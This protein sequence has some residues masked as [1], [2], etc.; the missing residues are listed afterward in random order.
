MLSGPCFIGTSSCVGASEAEA[1]TQKPALAVW[2]AP[3]GTILALVVVGMP[4]GTYT[5]DTRRYIL[6]SRQSVRVY[7]VYNLGH[8][9]LVCC[10]QYVA[11]AK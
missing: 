5:T 10:H 9:E 3:C 4:T 8:L 11:V 7:K 2:V 1:P 6:Y